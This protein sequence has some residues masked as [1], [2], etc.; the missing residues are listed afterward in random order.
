MDRSVTLSSKA[1]LTAAVVLLALAVAYLLGGGGGVR[2]AQAAEPVAPAESA[3]SGTPHQI[4]M[5]GSGTATVVPDQVG[6]TVSVA[7][8]QDSLDAAMKA[9]NASMARVLDTLKGYDV[10][11]GDVQ[12]TGLDMSP[13]YYYPS[14]AAPVLTGYRVTQTARVVVNDLTQAGA[15]VTAAVETG[16][17]G[18][19]VRNIRLQVADPERA[20]DRARDAAV[21]T[22]TTKAQQYA[23][24]TDA[25]LGDVVSI[26]EV[27]TPRTVVQSTWALRAAYDAAEMPIRAGKDDLTVKVQ[28]V[29]TL[30]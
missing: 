26:K 15:A 16:G 8:K 6:F 22:A 21:K 9:A 10:E 25:D 20:L 17:N 4:R 5:V 12:T 18:V 7:S 24:A 19:R 14:N 3:D 23:E 2:S 11:N 13:T 28:I 27:S 1:V 29:W 30:N